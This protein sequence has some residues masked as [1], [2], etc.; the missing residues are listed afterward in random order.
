MNSANAESGNSGSHAQLLAKMIGAGDLTSS[1]AASSHWSA[2]QS[3]SKLRQRLKA[4]VSASPEGP[5]RVFAEAVLRALPR[6]VE[7]LNEETN[8]TSTAQILLD[9]AL[10]CAEH[11][12][13]GRQSELLSKVIQT[14]LCSVAVPMGQAGVGTPVRSVFRE[15]PS[16]PG[17]VSADL[18]MDLIGVSTGI[19]SLPK[20]YAQH[21]LLWPLIVSE[22]CGPM[23]TQSLAGTLGFCQ[24]GLRNPQGP[25]G[26]VFMGSR[27]TRAALTNCM[28]YWTEAILSDVYATLTYGPS[29]GLVLCSWLAAVRHA[30]GFSQGYRLLNHTRS[31]IG[32]TL[33]TS[34]VDITRPLFISGLVRSLMRYP[35]AEIKQAQQQLFSA[36]MS[37]SGG[38][39]EAVI[40]GQIPH[41]EGRSEQIDLT[42]PATGMANVALAVGAG[43]GRAPL[44]V[45]Q[46]NSIQTLRTWSSRDETDARALAGAFP[47]TV[48]DGLPVARIL[49]AGLRAAAERPDDYTAI[50]ESVLRALSQS[51]PVVPPGAERIVPIRYSDGHIPVNGSDETHELEGS[52][53]EL[54]HH[55]EA[56]R[57]LP[58]HFEI[59]VSLILRPD[60]NAAS[61]SARK[62][63]E[64]VLGTHPA[65]RPSLSHDELAEAHAPSGD[66]SRLVADFAH[67]FGLKVVEV[68]SAR[69]EIV[70]SGTVNNVSRAF[71]VELVSM[72]TPTGMAY[73]HQGSIKLPAR[74]K[75]IVESVT[76]LDTLPLQRMRPVR[77]YS[78][79]K[80]IS[81]RQFADYYD[82]PKETTGAGQRVA[83][84]AIGGGYHGRDIQALC[85]KLSQ[86][87][88]A[89]NDVL[90][91]G[92]MNDPVPTGLLQE[93]TKVAKNEPQDLLKRFSQ[94]QVGQFMGTFEI[95][96]DIALIASLAPGVTIDVYFVRPDVSSYRTAIYAALGLCDRGLHRI[97]SNAP[98]QVPNVI[99]IS[100]DQ[101]EFQMGVNRLKAANAAFRAAALQNVTVC[102]ASGDFGSLGQSALLPDSGRNG[103]ANVMFPA[104]SPY[105]LSCGGT[106]VV[107][108]DNDQIKSEKAWNAK[109]FEL[110]VLATGGGVSGIIPLPDFQAEVDIPDPNSLKKPGTWISPTISNPDEFRGRGIPDVSANADEHVG[111][112]IIL[113]G[114]DFCGGG[115]SAAAPVWAALIA[116]INEKLTYP[117]G[118]VN[119]LLYTES[120]AKQF[121]QIKSGDNS[122][123]GKKVPFYKSKSGW[124]ACTGLGTPSGEAIANAIDALKRSRK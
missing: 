100:F 9:A 61:R 58:G 37:L 111:Y 40:Q 12:S 88:P 105:L 90:V 78:G 51:A 65:L 46:N 107:L 35:A 87:C 69:H 1:A 27:S 48:Q 72:R 89:I 66:H 62:N 52:Q 121:R 115:T 74:L 93:M 114:E 97:R 103:K 47:G 123:D 98:H 18:V 2:G 44:P 57:L 42:V 24:Q 59:R 124:N 84:I 22:L 71:G 67:A 7:V 30:Q 119:Q 28:V 104:S 120:V 80:L 56:G 13:T 60:A 45:L 11:D 29:F 17:F 33:G 76:G 106:T 3:P 112:H 43:F 81:P 117:V 70:L 113:G 8:R 38:V 101:V 14:S 95:T 19:L 15:Q 118:Y 41:A 83:V 102:C 23:I 122:I 34:P 31:G 10:A 20:P 5:N 96:M 92:A 54:A 110:Q 82:F 25:L 94:T 85:D 108:D 64:R 86:P 55:G 49:A 75:G 16:A 39:S 116:R 63:V 4:A 32:Q 73:A 91:G 6:F 36:C 109:E 26:R 53:L 50:S 68:A 77:N 99:S 21:P 79:G